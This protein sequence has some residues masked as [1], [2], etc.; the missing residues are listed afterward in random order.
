[1]ELFALN[2]E[3]AALEAQLPISEGPAQLDLLVQLAWQLRERDS[4][5]ALRMA[6]QAQTL[7][8]QVQ[9][10]PA[11]HSPTSQAAHP[12]PHT[13]RLLLVRG[14]I[15]TLRAELDSAYTAIETGISEFLKTPGPQSHIG[16]GDGYCCLASVWQDR[17]NAAQR[18]NCLAMAMEHYQL[19][20][21]PARLEYAL[22]RSLHYAAFRDVTDTAERLNQLFRPD[23]PISR[24]GLAWLDS[25]RAVVAVLSGDAGRA[26]RNFMSAWQ[27]AWETG[28]IRQAIAAASNASDAF[29]TLGDL[30]A[31]LE[32]TERA[33]EL[34]RL[35]GL[36][37]MMGSA[38]V[39]TGNLL[40]MLG[41]HEEAQSILSE[42][43]SALSAIAAS[44]M[45]V[46][47]LQYLG[48]LMLDMG[49]PQSA[50]NYFVQSEQR[51]KIS[52]GP[53]MRLRCWRGQA[54]ALC[55][56]AQPQ[57][58]LEKVHA[59]LSLAQSEHATDEQIKML[60]ILA[61]LYRLYPLPPPPGVTAQEAELHFLNQTLTLAD[62]IEG[63]IMPSELFDEIA[64][65]HA[66][67]GDFQA[68]FV[69]ELKAAN[70]RDSQDL[71]AANNRAIALQVRHDTE[72]AH[73]Q[74]AHHRQLAETESKRSQLLQDASATL[75]TLGLIGRE[76]TA[77]LKTEAVFLALSRHVNSMLDASSFAVYLLEA[78]QHYLNGVFC[79]EAGHQVPMLR[80]ALN[81]TS[82]FAARCARERREIFVDSETELTD[83]EVVPGTLDTM[84]LLFT[85]LMIGERLLGVMSIQSLHQHA[86]GERERSIFR[87]LC[88]YGAIALDNAAAYD[89]A[90]NARHHADQTLNE[91]RLAQNKLMQSEKMASLGRLV[92][93]I[94]HELNTPLGNGLTAISTLR[95]QLHTF[96]K[97]CLES[98]LKRHT[99][100][101][102]LTDVERASGLV[103]GSIE[104]SVGL[105]NSFKRLAV[106]QASARRQPFT[107][108][109]VLSCI[110][111]EFNRRLES[112]PGRT[113][114]LIMA[115]PNPIQLTSYPEALIEVLT[116]LIDNAIVHG[117]EGRAQGM[118][119]I[120]CKQGGNA[121]LRILVQDDGKGIAKEDLAHVFD[122]FFTTHFGQGSSGLGLH[123]AHNTV[124][125]VLGGTLAVF[126]QP[127]AG[128]EFEIDLPLVAPEQ[129]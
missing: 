101:S 116:R 12:P 15:H 16:G 25:A 14:V 85:P 11:T 113:Y 36:P 21:A 127:G 73:A 32:W 35:T 90:E 7:L 92:A 46:I 80:I 122:P 118:V 96:Q 18:D 83:S 20:Q 123:I 61:E 111:T 129:Q 22:A 108:S 120:R 39:Q 58:A 97:T 63:Y 105:V 128:C 64:A 4:A 87:T 99:F 29:S 24:A 72:R 30:D 95:D 10:K 3:V 94:A 45:Y 6:E 31:A 51:I 84:S 50:L 37:S 117:F 77:N 82:S 55:R 100:D 5:R 8:H 56:L 68:A 110:Q 43:Q 17:G 53:A 115:L 91:L 93:G 65:A 38:L 9:G 2:D 40:R 106:E 76:I 89:L 71:H 126:S 27:A 28:Q 59:A 112:L 124:T 48:E 109:E 74:A 107:I 103:L 79:I 70:A 81:E 114:Q 41:R 47:A 62:S 42:A 102:F 98:G 69:Y 104:R 26:I 13:A 78:D 119:Q 75:E 60:R 67:N 125:Q 49:A 52:D 1:M 44:S 86:Y 66:K 88:A 54:M 33:L 121:G 34:A 57:A 23:Q 19:A